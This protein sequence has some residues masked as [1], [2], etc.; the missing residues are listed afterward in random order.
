MN[1]PLDTISQEKVKKV[2]DIWTKTSTF[3]PDALKSSYA[4][5][6]LGSMPSASHLPD[7]L[8]RESSRQREKVAAPEMSVLE[9]DRSQFQFSLH[10]IIPLLFTLG[11]NRASSVTAQACPMLHR[12]AGQME[13]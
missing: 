5:F 12:A 4:K 13:G 10:A 2:L 1:L 8:E 7:S 9:A 3:T 6:V 11:A